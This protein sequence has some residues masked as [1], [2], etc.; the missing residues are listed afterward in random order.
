MKS[1]PSLADY[2]FGGTPSDLSGLEFA[3]PT[4]RLLEPKLLNI[5][6][7]LL[8]ETGDQPLRETG[9]LPAREFQNLGFEVTR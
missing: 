4:L 3:Q 5:D 2:L 6:I 7:Y 9:A 1:S 8:I